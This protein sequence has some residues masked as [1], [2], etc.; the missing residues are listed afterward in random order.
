MRKDKTTE[1]MLNSILF[2]LSKF[3]QSVTFIFLAFPPQNED[4]GEDG[5]DKGEY[6]VKMF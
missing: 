2:C 6:K 4:K 1:G 3:A 5:E